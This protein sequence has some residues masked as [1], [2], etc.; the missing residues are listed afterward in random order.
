M[1]PYATYRTL[2]ED[3]A[4]NAAILAEA[5]QFVADRA[6]VL[7]G[8]AEWADNRLEEAAQEAAEMADHQAE[9]S[10]ARYGA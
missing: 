5:I 3:E 10:F 8:E 7:A 9:V 1:E 6:A 4:D 2:Y